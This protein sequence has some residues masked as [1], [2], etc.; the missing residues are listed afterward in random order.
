MFFALFAESDLVT[1]QQTIYNLLY[2]GIAAFLLAI[3]IIPYPLMAII[4]MLT[5]AQILF[6][7]LGYMSLWGLPI[8][9]TTMINVVI[10]VGFSVDNA[11][12]FCHA[13]MNAPLRTDGVIIYIDNK[14]TKLYTKENERYARVLYA[15]NAVG[16]PILAGDLS[17]IVALL[18]LAGAQSE[19]FLSFWKCIVLVMLFGASHAVLY[20]PVV[21]SVI[22]PLGFNN[23]IQ[24]DSSLK[25]MDQE[26]SDNDDGDINGTGNDKKENKKNKDK[27]D[28][29]EEEYF[30]Q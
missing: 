15:L 2:A 4:V 9:T 5:V 11:A 28:E 7:V 27:D 26:K 17:T 10:S 30:K 25:A 20:L 22:G 8:N 18:P 19:I 1:I 14:N 24:N 6:G 12:H 3:I 21:L 13:F 29:E 16:M 23:I